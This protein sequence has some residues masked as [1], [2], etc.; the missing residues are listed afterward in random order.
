MLE[1]GMKQYAKAEKAEIASFG[2]YLSVFSWASKPVACWCCCFLSWNI[3]A[4]KTDK[5]RKEIWDLEMQIISKEYIVNGQN[6]SVKMFKSWKLFFYS[7]ERTFLNELRKEFARIRKN[8]A[9]SIQIN[10]KALNE[11]LLTSNL[12]P[13]TELCLD[14]SDGDE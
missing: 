1:H 5:L 2:E 10:E 14:G 9:S 11:N 8:Y 4:Q 13:L 7:F 6:V 3:E 12:L